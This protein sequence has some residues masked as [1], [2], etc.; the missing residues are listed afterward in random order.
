[1][2]DNGKARSPV[3]PVL[4]QVV[5]TTGNT[6]PLESQPQQKTFTFAFISHVI[7]PFILYNT[8]VNH[9]KSIPMVV[10]P[11]GKDIRYICG[12]RCPKLLEWNVEQCV[13]SLILQ[14]FCYSRLHLYSAQG[15]IIV[16]DD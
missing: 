16:I 3:I 9:D 13:V 6:S 1:M 15:S 14:R 11:N 2:F 4:R 12:Y 8:S 10:K 7:L 5:L